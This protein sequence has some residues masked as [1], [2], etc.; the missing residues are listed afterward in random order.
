MQ[1]NKRC[2]VV[3]TE[4]GESVMVHASV[5]TCVG[6]PKG[7]TEW[8]SLKAAELAGRSLGHIMLK[9][10]MSFE[11]PRCG[12]SGTFHADRGYTLGSIFTDKCG[13]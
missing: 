3:E 7:K 4:C 2:E 10:G 6:A 8:P 11:C 9:Q 5:C 12:A 1:T 13:A